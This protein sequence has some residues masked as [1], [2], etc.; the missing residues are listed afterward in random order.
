MRLVR[1]IAC[2]AAM[3]VVAAG[4]QSSSDKAGGSAPA[5]R[6]VLR[7]ASA[8]DFPQ[9]PVLA[10][11]ASVERRSRGSIRIELRQSWR[12]GDPR[13]EEHTLIDLRRD[14][15][16]LAWVGARVFD[17]VGVRSFTPLLA[18]FLVDS[19]TLE[20][21]VFADPLVRRAFARARLRGIVLLGVLPGPMRRLAGFAHPFTQPSDFRDQVVGLGDSALATATLRSLGAIPRPIA[22]GV[23]VSGIDG[24]EQQLSSLAGNGFDRSARYVTANVD[25][26][27]RPLVIAAGAK[28]LERLT[29]AERSLLREAMSEVSPTAMRQAV[30]EDFA[31]TSAICRSPMRQA[32]ASAVQLE[33]LR[34]T[35]SP[36]YRALA[37]DP[38]TRAL[39]AR[40]EALKRAAGAPPATMLPCAAL[41][42][43]R[44]SDR[45]TP[46]DGRYELSIRASDLPAAVRLPEQYGRWQIVLDR[47]HFRLT[48][49]SDGAN[50]T[51][52]GS[53]RVS[54]DKM[55]WSVSDAYD[56]SPHN[57]PDGPP[58]RP[59]DQLRFRWHRS[60]A[61]LGLHALDSQPELPSLG[62]RT[63]QRIGD[64]PGQ[65][66]VIDPTPLFGTWKLTI[67]AQDFVAH[68]ADL[69][70]VPDNSGPMTLTVGASRCG[71]S[72]R[73]P[74]GL[75]SAR[76]T[77]RFAGNTLELDWSSVDPKTAAAPY[78]FEWSVFHDRLTLRRS[79]GFSPDGWAYRPWRRVA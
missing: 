71:W 5:P 13:G 38:E 51:A 29:P 11:I 7:L 16:D 14:R 55:T 31:A 32:T 17:R 73:A 23:P 1:F 34:T 3:A 62:V 9:A 74:N 20:A 22:G 68:D 15:V 61:Q 49:G 53:V 36:I 66:Q 18:P 70:G 60:A 12:R 75:S 28:A 54:G 35:V 19:Y 24:L 69:N 78:F 67:T 63:L 52:D 8:T 56:E 48:Q 65:Q 79:P 37:T 59:G 45:E 42:G 47:G 46:V 30:A 50:W 10:W 2:L 76:G 4:C 64:A 33:L 44:A 40:I 39:M 27:P 21:R 72:Q 77:C 25:L 6:I 43:E 57:A 41:V 58:L 26:W